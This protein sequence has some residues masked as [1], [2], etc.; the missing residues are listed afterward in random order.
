MAVTKIHAIKFTLRKAVEY[1]INGDKT[2]DKILVSSFGCAPQTADYD[3]K[4]ALSH[5]RQSDTIKAFHLI[6]SFQPGEITPDEAHT[7]G[8]ELAGRLLQGKY[9]YVLATHIDKNHVHNHLLFCAANNIDY[10]KY[11]DCIQSHYKIRNIS[12]SLCREHNKSVI[13]NSRKI[14]RTYNEWQHDRKGDSWKSQIKKDI[15]E[16]IK[17]AQSYEE[18]IRLMKEKNYEINGESFGEGAAKYITF[19]PLGKDRFVRGR[20]SSLGAEYTK[21]RIRER[22]EDNSGTKE[23]VRPESTYSGT[24]GTA[25]EA[26]FRSGLTLEKVLQEFR[27]TPT[28]LIDTSSEKFAN[29]IG[30]SRWADKENMKRAT[31]ILAELGR[32]GLGSEK[33]LNEHLEELHKKARA[34]KKEVVKLDKELQ[35]FRQILNF[36]RQYE[37][38]KKYADAYNTS[39][40]PDRYYRSHH[41]QLTL[42]WGAEERLQHFG[43]DTRKFKLKDIEEHYKQ[44]TA[45]RSRLAESYKAKEAEYTRLKKMNDSIKKFLDEPRKSQPFQSKNRDKG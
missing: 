20:A 22:I 41:Y 10:H 45:D 9:S 29:S 2:D 18:F 34:D 44:L 17:K 35:N 40:D 19:R 27:N 37:E 28:D 26:F 7:I 32:L 39:K 31:A 14:N 30:L 16:C 15:D 33:A 43:V 12:D 1:I 38:N 25:P 21:E 6:Q 42:F 23:E 11:H 5:T 24:A 3:F 13:D 4:F 8:E 36:A